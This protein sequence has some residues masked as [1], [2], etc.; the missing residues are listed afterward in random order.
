MYITVTGGCMYLWALLGGGGLVKG[1]VEGGELGVEPLDLEVLLWL[2]RE[3]KRL[4]QRRRQSSVFVLRVG[5]VGLVRE[6]HEDQ[7]HGRRHT[8]ADESLSEED[9]NL[10]AIVRLKELANDGQAAVGKHRKRR[11]CDGSSSG[12]CRTPGQEG[13]HGRSS[14][15]QQR[16]AAL[17]RRWW[18]RLQRQQQWS[19]HQ[20]HGGRGGHDASEDG[21]V[22]E[23]APR[24]LVAKAPP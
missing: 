12:R 14:A 10:A 9:D 23:R 21:D 1:V 2:L 13:R 15:P 3:A 6:E 5:L 11:A 16:H 18:H 8:P 19:E 4:R 22:L 7:C 20:H 24:T 17:Q